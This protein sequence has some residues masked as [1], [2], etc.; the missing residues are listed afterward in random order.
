MAR[1]GIE[2][3][4]AYCGSAW[5]PAEELFTARGLDHTRLAGLGLVGKGVVL[6]DEDVVSLAATAARPLA[7]D[8]IRTLVVA[9]ESG[10]DMSKSVST[11]V[12]QLLGLPR[13][14]RLFEVKQACYGGIA[15]LQAAAGLVSVEPGSK[16]L[17]VAADVPAVTRGEYIEAGQGCG[18]VAVLVGDQPGVVELSLGD[19]GCYGYELADFLRPGPD[20]EVVDTDL[21]LVS[22]LD[23]L[24][25]AFA[26][27]CDRVPGTDIVTGFDMLAMHT[28]FPGMVRGAHRTLLRKLSDLRPDAIAED[29]RAR[30]EPSTRLPAT[31]GNIYSATTLLAML[32][33]IGHR[34]S[35]RDQ[36]LG[37]FSYGSGSAAEF[38]RC[39][40][41][42]GA[43]AVLPDL[44]ART[45]LSVPE[46]DRFL[47][48][49]RLL[50]Q[51]ARDVPVEVRTEWP[52]R[53][54][55]TGI[56]GY[57]REYAWL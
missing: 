46:Y 12:H 43:T 4:N 13:Q 31:A 9:T 19:S 24:L 1:I 15:A 33:A 14:C 57:Q 6:P 48:R 41:P 52:G 16:A 39:V 27:H 36:V 34:P 50:G 38:I 20:V 42:A 18:A 47:D 53:A 5:L 17:V 2:A 54:V 3:V 44:S 55:L 32:S 8:D 22:Y 45:R 21:S 56:S 7:R 28:P 25:G 30:V 10:V 35:T 40:V 49:T 29:Y 23:S 11:H 26:D 51:G 37:V